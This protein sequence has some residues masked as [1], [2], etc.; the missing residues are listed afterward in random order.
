MHIAVR[1]GIQRLISVATVIGYSRN[2]GNAC[3]VLEGA[4]SHALCLYPRRRLYTQ[5]AC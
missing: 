4:Q 1:S 3:Y 5:L 2:L